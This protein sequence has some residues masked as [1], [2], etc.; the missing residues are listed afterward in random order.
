VKSKISQSLL[1]KI[2]NGKRTPSKKIA[3]KMKELFDSLYLD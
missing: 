2:E 1:S 3:Q